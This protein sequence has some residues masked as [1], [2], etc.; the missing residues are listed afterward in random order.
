MADHDKP[1]D[2][3]PQS[4]RR[5]RE[6]LGLS[7]VEA[8]ELLGGGP[9]A[10]T[11]YEAGAIRPSAAIA[12]LLR[13]L[14]AN[15]SAII[16]L[17]GGRL[18]PIENDNLRP[19]EV[20]GKHVAALSPR[21]L[22]LLV[23]RLLD[24]EALSSDLPMDGVHVAANITAPD[25][26]ED[27]RIEWKNGPERT[28]FLPS[29]LTQFQLKAGPISPA[30]AGEDVLTEAGEV[31]PM[32]RDALEK[33]GT[34][35]MVCAHSYENKLIKARADSIRKG[36]TGAGL[37]VDPDKIQFRDAD[38]VATWVNTLPP[39]AVWLL[40]QTQ[41]GL[42]GP[43]K[44][45]AHWAGR[46][47]H[48][49]WV[50]DQRLPEFRAKL[51]G[52]VAKPGG[53]ARVVGLSGVGKSRL[54]HEALGPTD[55]ED[56]APRLNGLLFYA[57]ES[58]AGPVVVK[59]IIQNLADSGFRA[60]VVVDRCPLNT[61]QDLVGMVKR[62]GSRISLV[63]IDHEIPA[64]RLSDDT[65]R[66]DLAG[67][68]VVEGMIKQIAADLPSEDHRRLV[69][70]ARGFPQMAI[71]LGQAWLTD[72]SIATASDDELFDRIL[73]GRKPSDEA[74][75]KDAG[76][77]LGA[78]RLL[79]IKDGLKDLDQVAPFS[80]G[81]TSHDLRAAI[82]ELQQRGV[83]QQHG[84]L[85]S[86][87][88]KPL[89]MALAERRWRQWDYEQWDEILAGG[90][91]ER[92][93][94]HAA[95]QLAMLNDRP[96]A[97]EVAR[98]V[99][100]LNGPVA[101]LDAI[102]RRGNAD[103][104]DALSAIDAA[105]V[106]TLLE[107]VMAPLSA[108]DLKNITGD[109]RR[110][111]VRSLEKIAFLEETFE[112]GAL[113][114]LDLA[115]SENEHWSNNATGEFKALFPVF[116]SNTVAPATPR[117]RLF[118]DLLRENDPKRMP[119]VMDA[120]LA[121]S[122]M[123]SHSRIV[124]PEIHGSRPALVPW[125]PK[126]WKDAWDYVTACMDRLAE[127]ALRDD[128][129][130]AQ[131]RGGMAHHFRPLIS[132]GL[133]D[134]VEGWVA[135]VRAVHPYWPEAL[136][137]LGDLLQYDHD[138]LKPGEEAR[139]RQLIDALSPRDLSSRVRFIVTE[140]PWDFPF[141]KNL[142]FEERS[143][144]Q[145]QAVEEVAR[146]LLGHPN[147]LKKLLPELSISNQR[148]GVQLGTAIAKFAEHP[149]DWEEPIKE[150]FVAA[151]SRTVNFNV[152]AGYYVGLAARDTAGV[153]AFKK[154][155]A[156][157]PILAVALPYIC[158]Q[159]GITPSDVTLA[160]LGLKLGTIPVHSM[161]YWSMGGV[162]AK[163]GPAAV[164]PLFNQLLDMDGEAYSI[165]IDIMGMYVHSALDRLEALRPQLRAAATN[166][167]KR[168]NRRGSPMDAHHFARMIGWL[169]KKGRDDA[170]AKFVA[171]T[172]AKYVA[173][174]PDADDNDDLIKPLLPIMLSVFAPIVWPPLG[175]AI[176]KGDAA[177]SWRIENVLGHRL[178]FAE[179]KK[180]AILHMPEDILFA[181]AEA[182][183]DKGP[184]FLARVLPVLTTQNVNAKSA[185]HPLT[186]RLLNEFGDRDDVRRYLIQN[187]HTFGW[188]GSLTTYYALYEQPL[189]SL[190]EHPIGEVRRWAQITLTQMRQQ[191]ASA[192][193]QDDEQDAQWNA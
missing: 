13:L 188:S 180:P 97:A 69:K 77:L 18:V 152:L 111:L 115:A 44:D 139:V 80:R 185:F 78:F 9:R 103:I 73:L 166:I 70:F 177:V 161:V 126:Y 193:M 21:R 127:L 27:A 128:T 136:N 59:G 176:A 170:D 148:M 123:N 14:D 157:S 15:P 71:L 24:A 158:L 137:A 53:V 154:E 90:L 105:A 65:L 178:T 55:E 189:Q 104:V 129:L 86:L 62:A 106:V 81:R 58:E 96:I 35:V 72:A 181:W 49:P 112:R 91:P 47:D 191:I 168:P 82:D 92:L 114:M 110:N 132:A 63:T 52:L 60:I 19:F 40:E 153:E 135:K 109:T 6:K 3:L 117:L 174:T 173:E 57:V 116:L 32:V 64:G 31:Q 7:Q 172:L 39:V 2:L 164:T 155:A 51:R 192:K 140:M 131:A 175:M 156:R 121:A 179:E 183:P 17:S 95:N 20:T 88:P 162:L 190:S 187:M 163:L 10:F 133:I 150:A 8:G 145:I 169:L 50:Q 66:V 108:E 68:A 75:L 43:F 54:V 5:I 124:G 149:L 99:L 4:I 182:Y 25:G 34:Y 41:P 167:H 146:E 144:R 11:K 151:E 83:V 120:L 98:H 165:A 46:F 23:R 38:Q 56:S 87:Q 30:E 33:G 29:R 138:Q 79:G 22:M 186:M 48:S 85:V 37:R 122:D 159:I 171:G 125:Q 141:D 184:A 67:D 107:H 101:S 100:R 28:K 119:I 89:A 61:H 142:P 94:E 76:M 42:V 36:L 84:R 93:R 45:W 134:R 160:C 16:T 143:K 1:E 118:D 102:S 130:G 12:Q 74:L 147:E 113:L 26:G